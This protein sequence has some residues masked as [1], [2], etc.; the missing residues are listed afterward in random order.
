MGP[1]EQVGPEWPIVNPAQS[2]RS[3]MGGQEELNSEGGGFGQ[4]EKLER[5]ALLTSL[6]PGNDIRH[7]CQTDFN[8]I[9]MAPYW[10]NPDKWSDHMSP[11]Q[12][13]GLQGGRAQSHC[14]HH[15]HHHH[16]Q[17]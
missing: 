16:H 6:L 1:L 4:L 2:V 11:M 12:A 5:V 17:Q 8:M 10:C 15:H 14:Y 3:G 7:F 9:T 13:S